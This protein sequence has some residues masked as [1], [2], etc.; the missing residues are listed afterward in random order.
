MMMMGKRAGSAS[1]TMATPLVFTLNVGR[2]AA[3]LSD[4]ARR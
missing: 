3:R 4:V 2:L 1:L